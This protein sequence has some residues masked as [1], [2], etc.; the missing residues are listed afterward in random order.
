M[1]DDYFVED[2]TKMGAT[3][4]LM[5]KNKELHG[6]KHAPF[7][8]E[9]NVLACWKCKATFKGDRGSKYGSGLC[10]LCEGIQRRAELTQETKIQETIDVLNEV[11]Q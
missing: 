4:T 11:L 1:H 7:I 10:K 6:F 2:E 8:I 3:K 5:L 9:K